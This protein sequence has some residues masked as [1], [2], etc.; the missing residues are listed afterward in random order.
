MSKYII[1]IIFLLIFV[2][3]FA[4]Q[5]TLQQTV[6]SLPK[7]KQP[8]KVRLGFDI[9]KY[10]WAQL[11]NS[12]SYDVYVDANFYKKY[13]LIF[14]AGVENHLTE[15]AFLNYS[16]EGTYFKIGVDYNLYQN[17]L[18]MDNDI[19]V[20]F[21]YAS[22]QF[23]YRLFSYRINQPGAVFE[24]V[25]HDVNRSFENL[26]AQWIDFT[27]KIQAETFKHFYLGYALSVKY[28]LHYSHPDNFEVSYI[29]GFFERNAYSNFGFGMQYFIS[30][31]LKF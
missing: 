17:W 15:S 12:T 31:Q 16:T 14:E 4:Q 22:S 29:P 19:S 9:G 13:Y 26:S 30:Y 5:D 7:I 10:V 25:V 3:A 24:P 27:A 20:G 2:Q 11:N 6:D 18:D 21:R 1:N 23:D 8:V 28:L